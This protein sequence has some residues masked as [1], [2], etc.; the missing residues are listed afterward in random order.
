MG[1]SRS[2]FGS[3]TT[4][5][6]PRVGYESCKMNTEIRERVGLYDRY[7]RNKRKVNEGV[8]EKS[9]CIVNSQ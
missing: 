7:P 3:S 6:G 2:P 5:E 8:F 1:P 4:K 9:N